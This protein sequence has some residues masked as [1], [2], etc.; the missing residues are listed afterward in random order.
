[1]SFEHW[2]TLGEKVVDSDLVQLSFSSWGTVCCFC[3]DNSISHSSWHFKLQPTHT[4][5]EIT[6][7]F[8]L[9][10]SNQ[11]Q[12]PFSCMEWLA[13]QMLS[14][15]KC[16]CVPQWDYS[17]HKSAPWFNNDDSPHPCKDTK[18]VTTQ[19]QIRLQIYDLSVSCNDAQR[20]HMYCI[21]KYL[22]LT[23]AP[24]PPGRY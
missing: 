20:I 10:C 5:A 12:P 8:L 2:G 11:I 18:I 23:I 7:F 4:H 14:N 21:K 1:M 13:T 24:K 15:E 6:F 9:F 17:L 16:K 19:I 22:E 3:K